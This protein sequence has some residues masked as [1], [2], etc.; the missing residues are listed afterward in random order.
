MW[1]TGLATV[2]AVVMQR[3]G[4]VAT[5]CGALAGRGSKEFPGSQTV[6]KIGGRGWSV[7]ARGSSVD[8]R[9]QPSTAPKVPLHISPVLAKAH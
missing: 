5:N 4:L 1:L 7:Q 2:M 8:C 6:V 3:L 9:I